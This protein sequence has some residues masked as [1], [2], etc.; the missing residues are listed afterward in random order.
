MT[1][2]FLQV[3]ISRNNRQNKGDTFTKCGGKAGQS[4]N[5]ATGHI[6]GLPGRLSSS[7][8]FGSE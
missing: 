5:V 4:E 1:A 6:E 2:I 3:R 7:T 8:S